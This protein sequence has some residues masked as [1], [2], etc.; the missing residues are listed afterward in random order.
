M[1]QPT[2]MRRN[3]EQPLRQPGPQD[4]P[5]LREDGPGPY[6][7]SDTTL[8]VCGIIADN[9]SQSMCTRE[10]DEGLAR[11]A[12]TRSGQVRYCQL[13]PAP[14]GSAESQQNEGQT[15]SRA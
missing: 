15:G 1:A 3:A 14:L 12:V 13:P 8:I 2:A 4:V 5:L 10:K 11:R 7:S 9:F 6:I